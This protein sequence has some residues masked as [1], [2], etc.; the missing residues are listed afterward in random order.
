[1]YLSYLSISCLSIY[2][3]IYL[4]DY[5]VKVISLSA[6]LHTSTVETIV[7][8]ISRNLDVNALDSVGCASVGTILYTLVTKHASS[9]GSSSREI[10]TEL[11]KYAPHNM[12]ARTALNLLS[13]EH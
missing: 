4:I 6:A 8:S 2:L 1:M 10:N 9:I 13:A 3:S 11:E 5:S 12:I 7:C